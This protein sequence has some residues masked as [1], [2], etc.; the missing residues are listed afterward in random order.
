MVGSV[1][2]HVGVGKQQ[3]RDIAHPVIDRGSRAG[4]AA[5]RRTATGVDLLAE[6]NLEAQHVGRGLRPER[7]SGTGAGQSRHHQAVDLVFGDASLVEQLLK[8]SPDSTQT[9][10]SLFSIT[11]VSA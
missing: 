11:L 10:R 6:A 5:C 1:L 7:I 2:Q 4:D 9:L 8:I 3:E